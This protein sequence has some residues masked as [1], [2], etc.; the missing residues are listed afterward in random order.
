MRR[1]ST[2]GFPAYSRW[3]ASPW[4]NDDPISYPPVFS[5]PD[6]PYR[7]DISY[8]PVELYDLSM[9][10]VSSSADVRP[11]ITCQYSQA[12]IALFEDSEMRPGEVELRSMD[13]ILA[14][15][16]ETLKRCKSIVDFPHCNSPSD[17]M[18]LLAVICR[19]L[20]TVMEEAVRIFVQ[21]KI[22]PQQAQDDPITGG[23]DRQYNQAHWS[24]SFGNYMVDSETEWAQVIKVLLVL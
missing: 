22:A 16:K 23:D 3:S 4:I 19:K 24:L 6:N 9:G 18:L 12:I 21:Q 14:S 8:L 11:R 17:Q 10:Q 15:R 20:V 1:M 2:L 13:T 7:T 5:D